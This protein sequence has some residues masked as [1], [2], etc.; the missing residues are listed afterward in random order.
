M[1]DPIL[2]LNIRLMT[3][4]ISIEAKKSDSVLIIKQKIKE[5]LKVEEKDQR[6]IYK[7]HILKDEENLVSHNIQ[8]GDT[9]HLVVKKK[10][11]EAEAK[12]EEKKSVPVQA[13]PPPINPFAAFTN[14][15]APTSNAA[16][17]NDPMLD[18]VVCKNSN[19]FID[20][21]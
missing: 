15:N 3:D 12:P 17:M 11:T 2:K 10:T 18:L 16:P 7:G 21:K 14:Y 9:L 6:L 1:E 20:C 4:N 8:S 5:K 19:C 13:P